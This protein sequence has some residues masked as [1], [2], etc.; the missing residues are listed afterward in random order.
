MNF[1]RRLAQIPNHKYV[2]LDS[3][4]LCISLQSSKF[5]SYLISEKKTTAVESVYI[6]KSDIL[7][8][9]RSKLLFLHYIVKIKKI[10]KLIKISTYTKYIH[11][12]K[13]CLHQMNVC[14]NTEKFYNIVF[15]ILRKVILYSKEFSHD[16]IKKLKSSILYGQT[17]YK[18]IADSRPFFQ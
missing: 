9:P 8:A 3:I 4:Y 7:K 5:E 1:C 12:T 10:S 18:I 13:N 2:R 15:S 16:R 14:L 11:S 6:F 17:Q